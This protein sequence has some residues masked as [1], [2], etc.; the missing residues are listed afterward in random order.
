MNYSYTIE[1]RPGKNIP[2]ADTLSRS[3]ILTSTVQEMHVNNVTLHPMRDEGSEL[4]IDNPLMTLG[5]MIVKGWPDD[6]NKVAPI[7]LPYYNYR[8]E[9]SVEND[10]IVRCERIIIPSS[11][12]RS[13]REKM[14]TGHLGFNACLRRTRELLC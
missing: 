11:L 6:R 13:M 1:Y 9:L 8:D 5:Q 4:R 10:I 2:I 7:L 14:Y 12:R 3:P